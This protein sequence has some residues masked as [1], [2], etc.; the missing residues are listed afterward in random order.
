MPYIDKEV[1]FSKIKPKF[2][3]IFSNSKTRKI[4]D[5]SDLLISRL[6]LNFIAYTGDF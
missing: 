4:S 6:F 3:L 5:G 1:Y 2:S